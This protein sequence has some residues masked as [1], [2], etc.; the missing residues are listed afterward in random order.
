[1]KRHPLS[2]QSSSSVS[3]IHVAVEAFGY[4]GPCQPFIGSFSISSF[5]SPLSA[6]SS[7]VLC[8]VSGTL[9][10]PRRSRMTP[11]MVVL[12]GEPPHRLRQGSLLNLWSVLQWQPVH[13]VEDPIA[14]IY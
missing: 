4:C 3:A 2:P 1:M 5:H 9:L 10:L 8:F 12:E 7:S 6:R 13:G 11:P 14:I